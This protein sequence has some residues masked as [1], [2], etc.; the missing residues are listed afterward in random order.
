M[1]ASAP[2][3]DGD[4]AISPSINRWNTYNGP[5]W[6]HSETFGLVPVGKTGGENPGEA[7]GEGGGRVARRNLGCSRIGRQDAPWGPRAPVSR[8]L[9]TR[10]GQ[11]N[12]V[13]FITKMPRRGFYI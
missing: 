2:V 12:C 8:S 1:G 11:G 3:R 13:V 5:V 10:L 4:A 9:P 6:G 7:T